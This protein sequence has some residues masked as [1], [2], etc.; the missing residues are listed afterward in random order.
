MELLDTAKVHYFLL[1]QIVVSACCIF[2]DNFMRSTLQVQMRDCREPPLPAPERTLFLWF[3][4]DQ[5]EIRQPVGHITR[6]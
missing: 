6:R 4:G 5:A 1:G 2:F 3:V